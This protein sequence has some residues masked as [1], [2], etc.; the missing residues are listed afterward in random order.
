MALYWLIFAEH[1]QLINIIGGIAFITLSSPGNMV[2]NG[3]I[4]QLNE[5]VEKKWLG[6]SPTIAFTNAGAAAS[7]DPS[8]SLLLDGADS[9]SK[10]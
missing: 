9:D 8:A 1:Y 7:D 4:F 5:K 10:Q 2:T 3:C 6:W